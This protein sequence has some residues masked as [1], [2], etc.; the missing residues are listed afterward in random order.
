[1]CKIQQEAE[2]W[3][4]AALPISMPPAWQVRGVRFGRQIGEVF[5]TISCPRVGQEMVRRVWIG[6][7]SG[8]VRHLLLKMARLMDFALCP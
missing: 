7:A 1:M 5:V 2:Q 8:T 3:M 6:G 4:P